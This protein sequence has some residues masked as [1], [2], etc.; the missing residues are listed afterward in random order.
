MDVRFN[1]LWYTSKNSNTIVT[2]PF[3]EYASVDQLP[4]TSDAQSP[5]T[6]VLLCHRQA[7]ALKCSAGPIGRSTATSIRPL[8]LRACQRTP[9]VMLRF[10]PLERHIMYQFILGGKYKIAKFSYLVVNNL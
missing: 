10:V 7:V 5:I 9:S 3:R 6:K 8:C 4:S 1:V 2:T